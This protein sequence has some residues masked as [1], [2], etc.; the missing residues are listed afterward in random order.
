MK[1]LFS[2]L[3]ASALLLSSTM[4]L[5][6]VA[7]TTPPG[8][9]E[10]IEGVI[11]NSAAH[12][13]WSEADGD[14]EGYQIHYGDSPVLEPGEEFDDSIDVGDVLEYT[15][16]DLENG[17]AYY[18]AIIAYSSEGDESLNWSPQVEVVPDAD[19]PDTIN[20]DENPPQVVDAEALNKEEVKV[21][22][23]KA[24]VLPEEDPE[25]TFTIEDEDSLELLLVLEAVMDEEDEEEKTVILLTEP[26]EED[27]EYKLTVGIQVKDKFG[28][29]IVSG[30][31]DTALFIGSGEEKE[32]EEVETLKLMSVEAIDNTSFLV[33]FNKT[34][35][36][37]I[38][39]A[40]NFIVHLE[41]YP[42][43]ELQVLGVELGTNDEGVEDAAALITTA[44]QEEETYV[45]T[46]T[47]LTDEN[48]N[49]IDEE[50]NTKTFEGTAVPVEREDPL[51]P[52]PE[53]VANFMAK[54]L[55]EAEETIVVLTWKVPA[56]NEGLVVEQL[57]YRSNDGEQ[58][59]HQSSLDP[60]V[61]EYQ[62]EGLT[63]GEY[64]FK[65]TQKNE[66]GDESDGVIKKVIISE[67]GPGVIGLILAS[68]GLGRW[69]TKRKKI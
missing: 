41:G 22:F 56:E 18:F 9:V 50:F 52:T 31:S 20:G 10:H 42:T 34:V 48:E 69:V 36:L 7:E 32:V 4:S 63:A 49:E 35:I 30:T 61:E 65:I 11:L 40:D 2:F 37:S 17:T 14:V 47:G 15:V 67:T 39:P 58:F 24:V 43:Q 8:D 44:S 23:S 13:R 28:N 29:S 60:D 6:A 16:T 59:N 33:N 51:L 38:D 5:L 55:R 12:I 57:I 26:Q 27:T 25:L 3:L 46:V 68:L 53:D 45:L 64:W 54:T 21:E 62:I 66:E 19:A 1:K